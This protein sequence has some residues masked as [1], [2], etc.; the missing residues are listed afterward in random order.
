MKLLI[1]GE[2]LQAWLIGAI[3]VLGVLIATAL[4]LAFEEPRWG[5][6][7]LALSTMLVVALGLVKRR[8]ARPAD[9]SRAPEAPEPATVS[10]EPQTG[11]LVYPTTGLYR[12]WVFRQRL[13]EETARA[14]RYKRHLA[15]LLVE[16][17]NLVEKP[18]PEAYATAA[19][20]LRR[21]LRTSDF[22]GQYDEDRFVILLPETD[23]EGAQAAGQRL[24]A[25]IR[26]SSEPQTQWRGALLTYPQDTADPDALLDRA[27]IALRRGRL[28]SATKQPSAAHG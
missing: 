18:P 1:R 4:V 3:A 11:L 24:L 15:I 25:T 26:S 10:E 19:K 13:I 22:A 5:F 7:A 6:L 12:W 23:K 14:D 27:L 16:P 20:A 8:A 28:E 2:Q 9:A 21:A 17:A